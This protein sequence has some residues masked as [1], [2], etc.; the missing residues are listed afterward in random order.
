MR[1]EKRQQRAMLVVIDPEQPGTGGASAATHQ[2]TG[3]GSAGN[4]L[5]NLR[6]DVIV[7]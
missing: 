6:R 7:K 2:G 3:R 5:A 4:A 1:G